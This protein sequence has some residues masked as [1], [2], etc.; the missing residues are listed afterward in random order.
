MN[1]Y[2]SV[3]RGRVPGIYTDWGECLKQVSG[4]SGAVY[5]SFST[6]LEAESF[7]KNEEASSLPE[8]PSSQ[9]EFYVDGSFLEEKGEYSF[10]MVVLWEGE[11]LCFNGKS[12]DPELAAMRNVAGEIRGAREAMQ[13]ALE[14]GLNE[15][16][17]YH[18]YAGIA[19]WCTGE[20]KAGKPGTIAYRDYYE[21]I[22]D[23]LKVHFIKVKGHSHNHYNDLADRL[24]KEA[25]GIGE[26]KDKD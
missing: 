10:G 4:F 20:W 17:I 24:A 19:F 21:S 6:R 5:K 22:K 7:L 8:I 13:F 15:I 1:K 9:A 2:Y 26:S 12:D 3:R 16:S 23:L 11:E 25:L 14:H 18:D